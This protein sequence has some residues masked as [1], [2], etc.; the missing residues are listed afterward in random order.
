MSE[1]M[2][3]VD[4][5]RRF[6]IQKFNKNYLKQ[7]LKKRKGKCLKCGK[8]CEGCMFLNKKTHLCKIYSHRPRLMC[9]KEFPLDKFD[10]KIWH[11]EKVCGYKFDE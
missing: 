2:K 7:K 11:V 10:Q 3:V 8:C 6:I 9:Y 5:Y 1:L 4:G